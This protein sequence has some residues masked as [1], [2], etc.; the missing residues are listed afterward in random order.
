M[1]GEQ[2]N[3]SDRGRESERE[4]ERTELEMRWHSNVW[5][6]CEIW[7][8]S[9]VCVFVWVCGCVVWGMHMC[10]CVRVCATSFNATHMRVADWGCPEK[11]DTETVS[12]GEHC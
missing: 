9:L 2:R 10:M 4:T 3:Q 1:R 5:Y 11:L 12:R 7:C 8:M 6:K